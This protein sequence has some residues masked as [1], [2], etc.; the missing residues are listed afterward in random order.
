MRSLEPSIGMTL[1]EILSATLNQKLQGGAGMF[2]QPLQV[3]PTRADVCETLTLIKV[4][5]A[6]KTDKTNNKN[7]LPK[8]SP[9]PRFHVPPVEP[10]VGRL[11]ALEHA[12]APRG[13]GERQCARRRSRG[14]PVFGAP[15]RG[16]RDRGEERGRAPGPRANGL[17]QLSAQS[18][19][20]APDSAPAPGRRHCG[21]AEASAPVPGRRESGTE[22]REPRSL[23]R[24]EKKARE[25]L[26]ALGPLARRRASLIERLPPGTSPAAATPGRR[27]LCDPPEGGPSRPGAT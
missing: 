1:L 17:R 24:K 3:T 8:V 16:G 20:P 25:A 19:V 9:V 4:K 2:S 11:A 26:G 13:L 6:L 23:G 5:L 18:R 14:P 7:S 15:E 22:A 10:Q 21:S 27:R 12:E